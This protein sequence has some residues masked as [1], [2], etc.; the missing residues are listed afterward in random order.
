MAIRKYAIRT[1]EILR[2]WSAA[3]CCRFEG[4][5]KPPHSE[6]LLRAAVRHLRGTLHIR[7]VSLDDARDDFDLLMR[8]GPLFLLDLIARGVSQLRQLFE[9]TRHR[10][11]KRSEFEWQ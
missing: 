7:R 1:A 9:V 11:G 4:G 2:L 10:F 5:G 3:A 8:Y 6:G